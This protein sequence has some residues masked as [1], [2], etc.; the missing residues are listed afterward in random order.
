[1]NVPIGD[2]QWRNNHRG[3]EMEPEPSYYGDRQGR[4]DSGEAYLGADENRFGG[5]KRAG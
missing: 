2:R 4:H 1:M 3:A 5:E